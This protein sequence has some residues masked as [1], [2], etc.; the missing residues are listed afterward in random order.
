LSYPIKTLTEH[1]DASTGS[2]RILALDGGGVRG[3]LTLSYLKKIEDLLRARHG[4]DP[5]FRLCHYFDLIAGTSTGAVIASALACGL[6]VEEVQH[7]YRELAR[8]VFKGGFLRWGL[9]RPK[10][11]TQAL[12]SSLKD[13]SVL[14]ATTTLSSPRI[15]TG[16]MVMCKRL[17]TSS[18]WPLTN[19]PKAKYF[20][21]KQD[22][23]YI[24]N[25]DYL[26]WQV[27]RAST[28]APHY[29]KPERLDIGKGNIK[30]ET[31]IESGNFVDGGMST[32]NNPALQA[33]QVA[34]LT[35]F[36][37]GWKPGAENL[38]LISVG[39][40]RLNPKRKLQR[41]AAGHALTALLS[42]MEDCSNLVETH[43]QWMSESATARTIDSEIGD[44]KG[45]LI[46][47]KPLL[48]YQRYNVEF[49]PKW[50]LNDLEVSF[51]EDLLKRFEKMDD[52]GMLD[53]L[54]RL[55]YVAADHQIEPEHFPS[56]FD[57]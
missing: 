5:N 55:G 4:G 12:E 57:L 25:G 7:K 47:E 49:S 41:I 15:R 48:T 54:E 34:T 32:A 24:P 45:D 20:G 38:L 30:G 22:A 37:L 11:D 26:L 44:L 9:F 27:V 40:G 29:F 36:N 1:L 3:M 19:N 56:G 18:P 8:N 51:T 21:P 33:F 6:S 2:K 31:K 14:G 52:P 43:L 35:G 23:N 46:G 17:D 39:T 28:A 50:L 13:E 53:H 16:L 10:F 42:L